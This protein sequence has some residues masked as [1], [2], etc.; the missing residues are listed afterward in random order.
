MLSRVKRYAADREVGLLA[1][2]LR[3]KLEVTAIRE[4]D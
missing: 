2:E 1:R 4:I 3:T